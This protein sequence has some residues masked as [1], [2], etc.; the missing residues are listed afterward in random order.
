MK[1]IAPTIIN[2]LAEFLPLDEKLMAHG[3]LV[4][5]GTFSLTKEVNKLNLYHWSPVR[6]P[7]SPIPLGSL[8]GSHCLPSPAV[9]FIYLTVDVSLWILFKSHQ[10]FMIG[11]FM[12]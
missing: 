5:E 2:C 12:D 8:F 4:D 10:K 3:A 1:P 11:V 9:G 6:I 7:T